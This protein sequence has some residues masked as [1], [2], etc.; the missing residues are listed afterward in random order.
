MRKVG[1]GGALKWGKR[2]GVGRRLKA[3]PEGAGPTVSGSGGKRT[4][5][6]W[7]KKT[8]AKKALKGKKKRGNIDQLSTATIVEKTLGGKT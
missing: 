1:Q 8:T 4:A 3:R 2:V 7:K 6:N 5:E